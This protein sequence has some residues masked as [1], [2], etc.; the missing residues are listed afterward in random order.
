MLTLQQA[1]APFARQ[2]TPGFLAAM[3]FTLK[4]ETVFQSGHDGDYN[5][6][7]TENVP[8]DGGGLTRYG[9]DATDHPAVHI[10]TLTLAGAL[11]IYHGG[12]WS[13]IRGDEL[14]SDV[15]LAT[16]DAAVNVGTVRAAKWLQEAIGLT[17][18][19]VDGQVG[20]HTIQAAETAVDTA[21]AALV[22]RYRSAYYN[23]LAD[24]YPRDEQFE[25]GWQNR[26]NA[27]EAAIENPVSIPPNVAGIA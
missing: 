6:V 1:L 23:E 27:L 17:G 24:E 9:I 14:P 18:S 7:H 21:A 25:S 22:D 8:G 5:F 12:E 19:D 3:G 10:S 11:A 16:F 2:Y 13:A 20:P 4:W 26:T 15:A